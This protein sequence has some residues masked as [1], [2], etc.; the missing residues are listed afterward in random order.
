MA[1]IKTKMDLM[2]KYLLAGGT[3][4]VNVVGAAGR[5]KNLDFDYVDGAMYRNK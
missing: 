3:K 5:H 1:H 2:T 4:K